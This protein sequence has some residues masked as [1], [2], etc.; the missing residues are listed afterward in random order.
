MGRLDYYSGQMY[1][2]CYEY[3]NDE[4]QREVL[5]EMENASDMQY[6]RYLQ[7]EQDEQFYRQYEDE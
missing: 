6:M 1:G 4:E 3:L 7:D 2:C 5:Q